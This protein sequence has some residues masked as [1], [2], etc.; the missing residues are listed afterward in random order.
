MQT[1]MHTYYEIN[2]MVVNLNVVNNRN[3]NKIKNK[4]KK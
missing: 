2:G 3:R 1:Q 4:M